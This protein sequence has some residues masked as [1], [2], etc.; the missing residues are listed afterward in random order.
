MAPAK[1]FAVL[2][3]TNRGDTFNACD[4][5]AAALIAHLRQARFHPPQ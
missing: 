3:M 4:A 1:N 2:I 5:T